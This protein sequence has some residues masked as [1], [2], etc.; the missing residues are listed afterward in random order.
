MS[1]WTMLLDANKFLERDV[2]F[3]TSREFAGLYAKKKAPFL[4]DNLFASLAGQDIKLWT[5][6]TEVEAERDHVRFKYVFRGAWAVPAGKS[7][8]FAFA[9]RNFDEKSGKMWL[10]LDADPGLTIHELADPGGLRGKSPLDLKP[11]EELLL[12]QAAAVFEVPA[13]GAV[14]APPT[15]EPIPPSPESVVVGEKTTLAQSLFDRGLTAL[16][17]SDL[18]IGVLLLAAA[19]FGMAHAFTPGHGKT[20]VA[21]YLVGEQGTIGHA[22]TL[23][24]TTTLAHTGSVIAVGT[25]LWWVYGDRTPETVQGW[26]QLGGGAL[27]GFVGLWL[28]TRRVSGKADHVHIAGGHHHDHDHNLHSD[29]APGSPGRASWARVVMLGIGGGLI[30]CWDAVM[31]LSF[32]IAAGRLGFAVPILLAFSVGL[33]A[34]LVML[35]VGVVMAHRAGATRFGEKRWFRLLPVVSAGILVVMGL[36]LCRDGMQ[37]LIAAEAHPTPPH[38]QRA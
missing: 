14:P 35:G 10:T 19:V 2:K 11:G 23:G 5:E 17:D 32:A 34:V 29:A 9:D 8:A 20:L 1:E 6:K 3:S 33:A 13:T 15:S 38:G 26:L 25:I 36:W 24:L 21:A 30:P 16:F 27:I 37:R 22:L 7:L 12:R 4:I 28:F 31:L 18:G